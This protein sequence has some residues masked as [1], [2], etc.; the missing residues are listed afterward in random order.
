MIEL[1]LTSVLVSFVN[2]EMYEVESCIGEKFELVEVVDPKW[3][4]HAENYINP[5]VDFRIT[6]GKQGSII[7]HKIIR[8]EPKRIFDREAWRALRKWK[9]NESEYAER[10]FDVTIKFNLG[11]AEE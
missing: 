7:E 4:I 3:P 8:A 11:S 2:T 1:I 10:C 6:V 5:Y 9:F